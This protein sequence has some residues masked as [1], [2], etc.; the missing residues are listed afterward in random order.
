MAHSN[1]EIP[2]GFVP[3][4]FSPGF[5]DH[6]GPYYL[7]NGQGPTIV[8]CR[9]LGRHMN[10]VGSAHGGVL[11]TLADVTLSLAV[12]ASEEP[13][14]PVSTVSM[15][16]NFLSAARL[17]EWIEASGTIDRIGK[18]LAYAHGSIWCE[19]RTLMTMSAVFN[20]IHPKESA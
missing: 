4:G 14:R 12:Y 17:G 13:K 2:A 9:I 20:I 8:G 15:T 16:T 18:N 7:K 5:L 3:S 19:G 6:S 10:Y 1:I 11:A